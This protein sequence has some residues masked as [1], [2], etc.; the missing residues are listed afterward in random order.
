MFS[1]LYFCGATK[2]AWHHQNN[3][4][5]KPSSHILIIK[6]YLVLGRV[7]PCLHTPIAD[8]GPSAK[9]HLPL[10]SAAD[11]EEPNSLRFFAAASTFNLEPPRGQ[12]IDS[13]KRFYFP[14]IIPATCSLHYARLS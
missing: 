8:I 12:L 9:Q 13:S 11:A 1:D 14:Q 5:V 10:R 7:R 6:H 2:K 4:I 3:L